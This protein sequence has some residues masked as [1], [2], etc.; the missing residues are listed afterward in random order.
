MDRSSVIRGTVLRHA[1]LVWISDLRQ[2]QWQLGMGL[3]P[4]PP[5]FTR[6]AAGMAA[7]KQCQVTCA[8]TATF[9]ATCPVGCAGS[10]CFLAARAV[11]F[12]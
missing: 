11:A 3:K 8:H 4:L 1:P 12:S 7:F 10:C 6:P 9:L 2:Y 5:Q